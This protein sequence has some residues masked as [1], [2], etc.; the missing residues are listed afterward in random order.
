MKLAHPLLPVLAALLLQLA[1]HAL[2]PAAAERPTYLPPPPA[3]SLATLAAGGDEVLAARLIMLGVQAHDDQ[4][5]GR[6]AFAQLDYT[7]LRGWLALALALDPRAQ[8]PL[9]AA[10]EVYGAVTDRARAAVM[11]DFVA[12]AYVADPAN[13]WPWLAHAALAAEH[14]MHDHA[15][16]RA[17]ARLLRDGPAQ[18]PAWARELDALF[19]ANAGELDDARS[20]LGGLLRGGSVTDPNELRFL[21]T[22]LRSLESARP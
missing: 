6:L 8:A 4:A 7:A 14:R 3:P 1:W 19:A 12:T 16:A 10:S 20:I 18:V 22:K 13:R 21:E 5:A 15:R 17:Y 2:T 11:L 9:F